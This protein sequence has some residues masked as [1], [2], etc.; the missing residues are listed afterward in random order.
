MNSRRIITDRSLPRASEGRAARA[1]DSLWRPSRAASVRRAPGLPD[2]EGAARIPSD[3]GT[4]PPIVRIKVGGPATARIIRSIAG[5]AGLSLLIGAL[6]LQ[7]G[8]GLSPRAEQRIHQEA[9]HG[10]PA[11]KSSDSESSLDPAVE[12]WIREG[13]ANRAVERE[14]GKREYRQNLGWITFGGATTVLI[15]FVLEF[16]ALQLHNER[17]REENNACC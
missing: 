1:S 4:P 9:Y 3:S 16:A 10:M 5:A 17:D 13:Y 12:H 7:M 14:R 2:G 11:P 8:C 15:L 6:A